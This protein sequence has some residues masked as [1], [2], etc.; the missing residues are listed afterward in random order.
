[1]GWEESFP[2]MKSVTQVY[3]SISISGPPHMCLDVGSAPAILSVRSSSIWRWYVRLKA[4]D[5]QSRRA[6]SPLRR[7]A[8]DHSQSHLFPSSIRPGR[9]K[10]GGVALVNGMQDVV[11]ACDKFF[12]ASNTTQTFAKQ[13]LLSSINRSTSCTLLMAE[14]PFDTVCSKYLIIY[15]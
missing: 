14:V 6:S 10:N 8:S 1:M 9:P 4:K 5:P 7:L 12:L 2:T 3:I 15:P 13:S 11:R